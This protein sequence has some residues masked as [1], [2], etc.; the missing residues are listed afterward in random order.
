M[1]DASNVKQLTNLDHVREKF[2]NLHEFVAAARAT[3]NRNYWDYLIGAAET[4]TTLRRNRLAI[5]PQAMP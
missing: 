5:E 2:Q 3:L 1:N 4:E